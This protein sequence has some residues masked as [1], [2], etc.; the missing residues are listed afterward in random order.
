MQTA[1]I[2]RRFLEHFAQRGHTVVPSASLISPTRRCCSPWPAWCRSSRTSPAGSR[3]LPAGDQRAEVRPHPRHRGGGQDHP[4]RHVLPDERQLLLR[5]LLQGGRDPVRLGADHRAG[6]GRRARLRP[7]QDLGRP[8][9]WTTTRPPTPGT[10]SPA[11]PRSASSAWARRTTTGT[12]APPARPAR[13]RRSTSTAGRSSAPTAARRSTSPATGSSR[14]G[15]SSSCSTSE[16]GG[17]RQGLPDPRRAAEE[18]HRHRHGPGAGGLPAAG[19]R[20]HVRDRR[21][22]PGAA[23]RRRAGR[24]HLRRATTR[25]TSGCGSSPT[26]CAAG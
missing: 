25:T 12:P 4:A 24:R 18:E 21:G 19:R 5:R 9:T 20:Q 6:R 17:R 7:R 11:C 15:T 2:R 26:T 8:S 13:A 1:E 23:P 3:A 10:A 14:S 22:R 16:G